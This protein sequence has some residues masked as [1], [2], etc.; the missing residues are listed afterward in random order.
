MRRWIKKKHIFIQNVQEEH[1]KTA[2]VFKGQSKTYTTLILR[3]R[4]ITISLLHLQL[5]V[6][7]FIIP[8]FCIYIHIHIVWIFKSYIYIASRTP[9]QQSMG[10]IRQDNK[11]CG[12]HTFMMLTRFAQQDNFHILTPLDDCGS[13][14]ARSKKPTLEYKQTTSQLL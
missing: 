11:I 12:K 1:L 10:F 7:L 9:S 14:N 4:I 3:I 5:F 6:L 2:T 13:L 8:L